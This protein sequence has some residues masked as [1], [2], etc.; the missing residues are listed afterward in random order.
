MSARLKTPVWLCT[1]FA[2]HYIVAS[3]VHL[4]VDWSRESSRW[5]RS[6]IPTSVDALIY[7]NNLSQE[8]CWTA[9]LLQPLAAA[10]LTDEWC[11]KPT[12]AHQPVRAR[13]QQTTQ[14]AVGS[15][16]QEFLWPPGAQQSNALTACRRRRACAATAT[17][18]PRTR[19][20]ALGRASDT[21][22]WE[23]GRGSRDRTSKAAARIA[24]TS[25]L[26]RLAAP[27]R[28][29]ARTFAFT[30]SSFTNIAS[31]SSGMALLLGVDRECH[32]LQGTNGALVAARH[33]R[34][35]TSRGP[36][37]CSRRRRG[38]LLFPAPGYLSETNNA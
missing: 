13:H 19:R 34:A 31:S 4:A 27:R 24:S 3:S 5:H 12:N 30:I 6:Q 29:V 9:G 28:L 15:E 38:T 25:G 20:R 36:L 21:R 33:P 11:G 26:V 1:G 14:R 37:I 7:T 17:T 10:L 35:R 22:R 2:S 32:N 18:R 8:L 23:N 16:E